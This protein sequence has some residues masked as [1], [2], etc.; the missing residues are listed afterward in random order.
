M[1]RTLRATV[2]L[3]SSY[4]RSDTTYPVVY[5]LHG[6]GSAPRVWLSVAPLRDLADSLQ[7]IFVAPS[8]DRASWWLDSPLTSNSQFARHIVDEVVP[9][10]D[11]TCRTIPHR[12][13]RALL[14]SSMGGHGA[15]TIF[16]THRKLF[17][18]AASISGI[19]DL[20]LFSDRWEIADVL[21]PYQAD[22]ARWANHSFVGMIDSLRDA[23]STIVIA[24]GTD[25]FALPAN[26]RAHGLLDSAGVAHRYVEKPGAHTRSFVSSRF[27][28]VVEE[29][30]GIMR[31]AGD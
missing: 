7:L 25:D 20:T 3:P 5:L 21:G 9:F 11:S 2:V 14:G 28:E 6:Y 30:V 22:S 31:R 16:A 27:R 19:L 18:G 12:H 1:D 8:G 15:L 13:G 26:R 17:A 4:R 24:C 29:L 10:I 23:D